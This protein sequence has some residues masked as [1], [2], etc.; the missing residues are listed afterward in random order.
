MPTC[1]AMRAN[2]WTRFSHG[3]ELHCL[4]R[5]HL[6]N[7]AE[8][9]ITMSRKTAADFDPEVMK[10]FDQYVHG[11]ISRRGFL[12]SAGQYAVG[13]ATAASRL[14]ALSPSFAAPIVA[15]D[16]SR[17]KVRYVEYPSPEGSGTMRG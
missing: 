16:D 11:G 15:G 14:A 13:G 10:L 1:Q 5:C 2:W 7:P 4:P 6:L 9:T 8:R 17:I 12:S 3:T